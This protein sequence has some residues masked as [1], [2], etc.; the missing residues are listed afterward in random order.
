MGILAAVVSSARAQSDE[1]DEESEIP[2]PS[3]DEPASPR[4][5]IN[6]SILARHRSSDGLLHVFRG[7]LPNDIRE[8][9]NPVLDE[10]FDVLKD[11]NRA[12]SGSAQAFFRSL[13][14]QPQ[15]FEED[16][17][18]WIALLEQGP[19]FGGAGG[20]VFRR[21]EVDAEILIQAPH[22]FHDL[23]TATI[24]H[25]AFLDTHVRGFFFNTI[26]RYRHET[27]E[28]ASVS[29]PADLAHNSSSIFH[30]MSTRFLELHPSGLV[31]QIHGFNNERLRE[32]GIHAVVSGGSRLP[33]QISVLFK[34]A[35]SECHGD[36]IGLYGDNVYSYGATTN[37]L[38]RWCSEHAGERF[39][40]L[41]LD[42]AMRRLMRDDPSQLIGPIATFIR[43]ASESGLLNDPTIDDGRDAKK[44]KS[45]VNQARTAKLN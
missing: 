37:S 4:Y 1:S 23:M 30:T 18:S 43:R 19:D 45:R 8:V 28:R 44:K 20:Y 29:H 33:T 42:Y 17:G 5:E 15:I 6:R 24:A 7:D 27:T 22:T 2:H 41:E 3:A 11:E 9:I 10:F 12:L 39:L 31:L 21:G 36:V 38:S 16:G 13:G 35:L 40:H 14:L 25:E 26:H 34:D 32:R